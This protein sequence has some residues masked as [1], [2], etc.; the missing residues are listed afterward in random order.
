MSSSNLSYQIISDARYQFLND[1]GDSGVAMRHTIEKIE[2]RKKV[3]FV[4]GYD[5]KIVFEILYEEHLSGVSFLDVSLEEAKRTSHQGVIAT[6]GC[7]NVKSLLMDFVEFL[8]Q[9]QRF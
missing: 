1:Q 3:I 6:G 8:P 9:E 2:R 4:E 7:D 5:D